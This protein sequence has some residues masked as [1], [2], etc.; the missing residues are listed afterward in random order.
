M[1]HK[2]P[3]LKQ[4]FTVAGTCFLVILILF[5][6]LYMI[7]NAFPSG[8]NYCCKC[9][10]CSCVDCKCVEGQRCKCK[11]CKD[12]PDCAGGVCPDEGIPPQPEIIDD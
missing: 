1:E 5:G 8:V 12:C 9:F 3:S 10:D 2:N 4:A 7:D 6:I 11:F